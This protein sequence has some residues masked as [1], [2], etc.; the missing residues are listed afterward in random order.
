METELKCENASKN[1][2]KKCVRLHANKLERTYL[3]EKH[4]FNRFQ[5]EIALDKLNASPIK[6]HFKGTPTSD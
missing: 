5:R 1:Q 3:T 6:M 2:I 4:I